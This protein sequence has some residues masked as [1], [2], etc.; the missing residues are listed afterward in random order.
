MLLANEINGGRVD[1]HDLVI[2][3]EPSGRLFPRPGGSLQDLDDAK[4]IHDATGLGK[5]REL[6]GLSSGDRPIES[7]RLDPEGE[8]ADQ[9]ACD[10]RRQKSLAVHGKPK[11]R[12]DG[13][14]TK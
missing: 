12:Q 7:D 6:G 3:S 8:P 9:E 5:P 10:G 4:K 13:A 2:M 11:E 1:G 14:D